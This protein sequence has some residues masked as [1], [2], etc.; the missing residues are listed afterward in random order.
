MYWKRGSHWSYIRKSKKRTVRDLFN[1]HLVHPFVYSALPSCLWHKNRSNCILKN[2][3]FL[4]C[5]RRTEV[6]LKGGLLKD[7]G[8]KMHRRILCVC[9]CHCW[10]DIAAVFNPKPLTS[11][12]FSVLRPVSCFRYSAFSTC[13]S[14]SYH[15]QQVR[16]GFTRCEIKRDM[17][18]EKKI[19][20]MKRKYTF[21]ITNLV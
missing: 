8:V 15:T 2:V 3:R 6:L 9:L 12:G 13:K 5:I 1:F 17:G 20:R 21:T 4:K 18:A 14:N 16:R 7:M 19:E 10:H 11:V